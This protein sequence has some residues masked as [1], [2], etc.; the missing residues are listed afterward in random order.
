MLLKG[1]PLTL[2]PIK[3]LNIKDPKMKQVVER[4]ETLEQRLYEHPLESSMDNRK[5]Y[6]QCQKKL[7]VRVVVS[8]NF[9]M[10]ALKT[11]IVCVGSKK[12]QR[13]FQLSSFKPTLGRVLSNCESFN[14]LHC[15]MTSRPGRKTC[16]LVKK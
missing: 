5:L 9:I 2:D 6:K 7:K 3:D 14:N 8:L 16:L 13:N 12:L 10:N 11:A 15:N 1:E 4:I